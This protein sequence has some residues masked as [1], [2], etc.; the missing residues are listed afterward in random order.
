MTACRDSQV[1]S[2]ERVP[3]E[4]ARAHWIGG[5]NINGGNKNGLLS[6]HR[7]TIHKSCFVIASSL[8]NRRCAT[9]APL[10]RAVSLPARRQ[11]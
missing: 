5:Y 9:E 7:D 1:Q 3:A 6:S 10:R 2:T 11:R 8:T 4:R